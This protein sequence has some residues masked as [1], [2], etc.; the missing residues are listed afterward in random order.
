MSLFPFAFLSYDV[1]DDMNNIIHPP[2]LSL[3]VWNHHLPPWCG[4]QNLL[5]SYKSVYPQDDLEHRKSR[6][7]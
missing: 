3:P 1:R 4:N 5:Y 6:P 2:S 7:G